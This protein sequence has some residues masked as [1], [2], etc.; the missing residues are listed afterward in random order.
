MKRPRILIFMAVI[1]ISFVNFSHVLAGYSIPETVRVGLCYNST[2]MSVVDIS[3]DGGIDIFVHKDNAYDKMMTIKD[4][5]TI[6]VIKD[7][8]YTF[9]NGVYTLQDTMQ[10]ADAGP[11]HLKVGDYNNLDEAMAV[12][13]E[14]KSEGMDAFLAYNS[15]YEVWVGSFIDPTHINL[16]GVSGTLVDGI[17][18]TILVKKDG[19]TL[20][21]FVNTAGSEL[22]FKPVG[23]CIYEM[24]KPY[25]GDISFLRNDPGGITVVN[26]LPLEEYL[27]G[28]LPNEMPATWPEEALKAQAV[29]ARTY[30]VYNILYS[31]KFKSIGFDVG[32]S[33][34]SQVYKGKSSESQ[35]TNKAVDATRGII[36]EYQGKPIE[37]FFHAHSG[38]YTADISDIYSLTSPVF[39]GKK[40]PYSIG[41][42]PSYDNWSVTYSAD[43]ILKKV[44]PTKG[45]IGKISSI[46]VTR[47]YT[48]RVLEMDIKGT[49]GSAKMEKNEIRNTLGLKSTLFDIESDSDIY[50]MNSSGLVER[51]MPGDISLVGGNSGINVYAGGNLYTMGYNIIKEIPF[52][53]SV[54]TLN[55]SGYGHGVGMSQYGARGM[56]DNGYGFVDILKFYYNDISVYD[57]I[58]DKDI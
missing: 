30:A 15:G 29:A 19:N 34:D 41:Y 31:N 11:Y 46:D 8:Y 58:R 10:G 53:P 56:A 55:G 27:Y 38:G 3:S 24:G 22:Y 35:A 6:K 17:E 14:L 44:M 39:T 51:K 57:T 45:D 49:K 33:T 18:D 9:S 54:F 16:Q 32:C 12:I 52:F 28:V 13:S 40:D 7:G 20:M 36:L 4:S 21:A 25:R 1:V 43:D 42:A 50:V 5:G 2:A 23:G 26:I 47:S 48:G 37:A